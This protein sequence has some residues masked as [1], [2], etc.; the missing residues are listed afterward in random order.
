MKDRKKEQEEEKDEFV[1]QLVVQLIDSNGP[2]SF[3]L[4]VDK[5]TYLGIKQ[6][7]RKGVSPI[8]FSLPDGE[9]ISFNANGPNILTVN[10][11]SYKQSRLI[12]AP[13]TKSKLL[14]PN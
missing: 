12:I 14:L 2:S 10:T 5:Q 9:P 3:K 11:H 6:Q 1:Y 8:I 13:E 7:I 4:T